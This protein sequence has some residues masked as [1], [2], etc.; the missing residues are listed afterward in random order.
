MKRM[1]HSLFFSMKITLI[2]WVRGNLYRNVFYD[3]QSVSFQTYTFNRIVG[4][5]THLADTYF[6]QYL[7]TYAV[8]T[9]IGLVSQANVGINGIHAIFLQFVSLH[10]FH[11]SD[12]SAFLIQINYSSFAGFFYH[13]QGLVELFSAIAAA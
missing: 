12:A 1:P 13:S 10:F 2:V 3:L 9:F 5:E 6:A 7:C 8:I 4:D 11:E